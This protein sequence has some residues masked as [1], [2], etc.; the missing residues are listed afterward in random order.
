MLTKRSP[1]QRRLVPTMAQTLDLAISV[2]LT[3]AQLTAQFAPVPALS[4]AV[5]VLI[6]IIQTCQQISSSRSVFDRNEVYCSFLI[7]WRR[8]ASRQLEHRCHILLLAIRDSNV[9]FTKQALEH[10][11]D[12]AKRYA[13]SDRLSLMLICVRTLQEVE[14]R[15]TFW[16]S[17]KG[18]EAFFCQRE[19]QSDI[20]RCQGEITTCYQTLQ[21]FPLLIPVVTIP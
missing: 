20:Q 10:A 3:T 4:V 15:M 18:L 1:G 16:A 5:D 19:I 2:G 21:V 11:V 9:A 17:K 14:K 6:V 8:N 12:L 7:S 13:R